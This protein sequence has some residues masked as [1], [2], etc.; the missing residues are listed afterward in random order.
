[1]MDIY[2]HG[3]HG[4]TDS[5]CP[6]C[7]DLL[8]YA[9]RKLDRCPFENQPNCR[10]CEAHCYEDGKRE[11][12]KTVMRYSGS[13]MLLKHPVLTFRHYLREIHAHPTARRAPRR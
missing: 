3:E 10:E 7:H 6:A 12:I 13:R 8:E 5:L 1:M 11:A 4:T 2:C 9:N